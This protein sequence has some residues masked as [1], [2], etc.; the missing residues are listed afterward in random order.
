MKKSK[1]IEVFMEI[2][3]MFEGETLDD[4]SARD[5][6]ICELLINL[7]I[8]GSVEYEV[9]REQYYTRQEW[10]DLGF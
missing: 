6:E 1:L 3:D 5:R 9:D 2:S 10:G 4:L 8:G 7:E